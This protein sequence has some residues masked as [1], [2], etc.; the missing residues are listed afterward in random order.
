MPE[1]ISYA[2]ME[3]TAVLVCHRSAN[4]AAHTSV[5]RSPTTR[6][7]ST[8]FSTIQGLKARTTAAMFSCISCISWLI[9][10]PSKPIRPNFSSE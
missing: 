4:G 8:S 7:I 1:T 5:G 6:A 9:Q 3:N 2:G 10:S